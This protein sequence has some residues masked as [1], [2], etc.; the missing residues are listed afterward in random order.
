MRFPN[1]LDLDFT[2]SFADPF[3]SS[4]LSSPQEYFRGRLRQHRFRILPI[5]CLHLATTLES[6]DDRILRF[7]VL[8]DS[9]MKLRQTLQT[10]QLVDPKPDGLLIRHRFIQEAQDKS[11]DP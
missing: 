11:I 9:G 3:G 1:P 4:R 10:R 8:S 7:P 5:P 2:D 6:E